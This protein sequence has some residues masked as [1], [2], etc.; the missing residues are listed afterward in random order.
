M[1]G[2][3]SRFSCSSFQWHDAQDDS[4]ESDVRM[5][6]YGA[7]LIEGLVGVVALD[8]RRVACRKA[9]IGRSTFDLDRSRAIRRTRWRK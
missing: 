1:C 7:M 9:I 6:G 8:R 3:I 2:A 4:Q 5:I